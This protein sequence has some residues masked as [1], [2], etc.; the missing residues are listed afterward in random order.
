MT[1]LQFELVSPEKLLVS[2]PVAMVVVP[3]GEGDYGVLPQHAPLIT[4][5]RP[6]V[7]SIYEENDREITD[8]IFVSGGFAEVSGERCTVLAD[9][10]VPVADIDAAKVQ[11]ELQNIAEDL[12]LAKDEAAK[13]ILEAKQ[14]IAS[15]KLQALAA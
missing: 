5:L 9:E 14:A 2:K 12:P 1:I 4:T 7:I 3:G 10:A 6:G 11:E 13:Q 8:L 15:A